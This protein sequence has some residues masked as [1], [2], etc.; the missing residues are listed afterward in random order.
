M[1]LGIVIYH[2]ATFAIFALIGMPV[3]VLMSRKLMNRM[4][5]NN[6]RSAALNAEMSGFNQESLSNIQTIKAF[7]LIKLYCERLKDLQTKYLKMRL[8]FNRM[9]AVT[10]FIMAIVGMAVSYSCYGWGIYRVWSGVI[11]Y[12]TMTMF[13]SLSGT[14]TSSVNSLA[15]LIPS[16]VSLTI[17]AGRLMDI[18]EMP[19]ED[20]SHDKEVE[21]FEKKYRMGG[22]LLLHI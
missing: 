15:G 1:A 20:Y 14:L 9:S 22:C 13:L 21:V 5:N 2:D 19:Q 16:A 18:V 12:G 6:K 17:S 8:E 7:D 11:S 3:S 10:S 4:V